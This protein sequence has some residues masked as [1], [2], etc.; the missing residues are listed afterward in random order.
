[1]A[2]VPLTTLCLDLLFPKKC[3][4]CLRLLNDDEID[5]QLCPPCRATL[6]PISL[7]YCRICAMPVL[8]HGERAPLCG[9]CLRQR[10]PFSLARALF[11][12]QGSLVTLVHKLKYGQDRTVI[13]ALRSL[14][15]SQDLS[16]FA[17]GSY[18]VPV[19]LHPAKLRQRGFNQ[20]V[21]LA[22]IFFGRKNPALA[23]DLLKRQKNTPPQTGRDKKTRRKMIKNS[24]AVNEKYTIKSKDITLVDDVFTTGTTV[25]Q[26]SK[27]LVAAGARRV[28]VI[29][30]ARVLP[31]RW[32]TEKIV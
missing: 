31:E 27:T 1:M 32:R 26:C 24:F 15:K 20:A 19:P 28:F 23:R 21:L 30:L 25:A 9:E 29:T 16:F 10:P 8:A 2:R 11:E 7:P 17:N 4:V 12:Y 18:L 14:I 6:V 3:A 13:P 22:E 5:Q